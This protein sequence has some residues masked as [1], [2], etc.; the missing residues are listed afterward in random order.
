MTNVQTVKLSQILPDP[1]T[2]SRHHSA[3]ETQLKELADNIEAIGLILPLAVRPVDGGLYRI[4]DGHRR[5]QALT[6]IYHGKEEETD[7]P[8]LVRNADNADARVLS[9]AANIMRLPLHPADQYEAFAAMLAEGLSREEIATRFALPVKDVDKRLAL[10]Q[11]AKPFLDA[12]RKD[13]LKVETIMDL[14]ALSMSRQFEVLKLIGEQG[15]LDGRGVDWKIRNI[16]ND[17]AVFSHNAVVK[18]VGLDAYEAA[19]GRVERSLFDDTERLVDTDL[20]FKLAEDKV[21]SWVEAMRGQGWMFAMRE[22]DAPKNWERFERHYPSPVLS[23]EAAR[24]KT[25]IE[26]RIDEIDE[27]DSDELSDEESEALYDERDQLDEELRELTAGAAMSYS[28]EEKAESCCILLNDWRVTYG[29]IWP[30]SKEKPEEGAKPEKP[31]VKGWSQALIDEIDAHGS[32][33]AQ[34]AIMREHDTADCMLLASLYQDAVPAVTER[35]LAITTQDR[36]SDV[37]I[38]AGKDI[39]SAL[40][41]FGLKGHGFWSLVQQIGK[42]DGEARAEL[43]AVLVARIMRKRRGKELEEMF[44]N[45][46][47]ANVLASWKP[48]KEFFERLT[49]AQLEEVHK[50]LTGKGFNTPTTKASA[51]AM[52]VTQASARNWVPKWLRKGMSSVD[53]VKL[54]HSVEKAK[55]RKPKAKTTTLVGED[56][57]TAKK[58]AA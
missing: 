36:F 15:G 8:V 19:G 25:E 6:M 45:L 18:F 26:A 47:T 29:V 28:D 23:D 41:G 42:L 51:V 31:E 53:Q 58:K 37:N 55:T 22:A 21:P 13:E 9:L 10:G 16:I 3:Y 4:L 57:K 2:N 35:V 44:G 49:T 54:D 27:I 5:H 33:A 38:N 40:K 24:R 39:Q 50:E 56:G 7:V 34:L 11:V 46:T 12:Y 30:K 14:S 1:D 43:R 48:E 17:K 20:L 52:V 32:V